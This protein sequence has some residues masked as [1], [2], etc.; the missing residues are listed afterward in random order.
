MENILLYLGLAVGGY[1]SGL[2]VNFVVD[3]LY[4]RRNFL[5]EAFLA[6]LASKG[7]LK[8]ITRPFS[9]K[10]GE[11]RFKIRSVV[12]TLFFIPL[13]LWL[14]I[15]PPERVSIWWGLP[16]LMYF[17]LVIVMDI[18]YRIVM[19][20]VSIA[21]VV[22]GA[23]VGVSQRGLV[24]TLVGGV[25]GF[26][27]M[28]L[29]FKLG[30]LFVKLMN[31]RRDGESLDEVALGFGDVNLAGVV[32]LFLGW[33]PIILGLL[34]AVFVGGLVSLFLIFF[35]LFRKEFQAFMAIPYAPFLA[36][37]ALVMLFFPNEIAS[38]LGG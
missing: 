1:L 33:P 23:A 26:V 31:R 34:F 32:G 7:W 21:G 2:V 15:S 17:S 9:Y 25:V 27:V 28:F 19:H 12:I 3:W 13:V 14:G 20:P 18:E 37:A 24:V 38:L 22:L 4:L 11:K 6:E 5:E 35:T 8:F 30:E 29:L 36:I 10:E 16:V